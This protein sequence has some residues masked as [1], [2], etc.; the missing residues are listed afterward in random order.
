MP[1]LKGKLHQVQNHFVIVNKEDWPAH[2][3]LRSQFRLKVKIAI[4][5]LPGNDLYYVR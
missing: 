3:R 4:N 1:A 2:S 5:F